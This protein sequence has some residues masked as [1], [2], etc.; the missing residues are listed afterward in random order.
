MSEWSSGF[1]YFLQLKPEFCNRSSWSEPQS[2]PSL[3][4]ADYV[5]LLRLRLKEYN[6]FDFRIDHLL[7]STDT[8]MSRFVVK[9]CFLWRPCS[10]DKTL[11]FFTLHYK[12]KL[13]YYSGYLLIPPFAFQFFMMKR[14][15]FLCLFL[16]FNIG[17][18]VVFIEP[19][20]FSFFSI[21][22]QGINLDY[23]DIEWFALEMNKDHSVIFETAPK[24]CISDS[25][26]DYEGYSISYK[27]F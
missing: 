16:V 10:L 12:A 11:P 18:L 8:V 2:A 22:G 17:G 9:G 15:S 25:S 19:F 7:M 1:L 24:Y 26:F 4:F 6:Q 3:F 27:G 5:W 21:T 13:A 14:K 20:N 23:H